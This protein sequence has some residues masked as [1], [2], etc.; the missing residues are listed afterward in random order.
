MAMG[1]YTVTYEGDST[2][3]KDPKRYYKVHYLKK[4][5]QGNVVDNFTLYPDAFINPQGQE[6][7]I[8]NPDSKHYWNRDIFTYV[9]SVF[10]ASKMKDTARYKAY[11]VAPG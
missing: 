1:N 5:E 3:P 11:Q 9:T 10:D 7:L 6:G 4:D 2:A 8:A